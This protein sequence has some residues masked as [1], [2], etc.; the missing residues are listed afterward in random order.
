[1]LAKCS[2]FTSL[3][4]GVFFLII[5][6][7]WRLMIIEQA[8][9]INGKQQLANLESHV[10][11]ARHKMPGRLVMI[12]NSSLPTCTRGHFLLP[13]NHHSTHTKP[14]FLDRSTS[15][16]LIW[17]SPETGSFTHSHHSPLYKCLNWIRLGLPRVP[18]SCP[19]SRWLESPVIL[20]SFRTFCFVLR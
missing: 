3:P 6:H 16:S 9:W 18:S 1:M 12:Q 2:S 14:G 20:R 17:L 15:I 4:D 7:K 13:V 8:L 10:C 5:C 19:Y 11:Y